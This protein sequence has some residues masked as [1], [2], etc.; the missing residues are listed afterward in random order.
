MFDFV[1]F[2]P[3]FQPFSSFFHSTFVHFFHPILF[4]LLTRMDMI[5]S[6]SLWNGANYN[7]IKVRNKLPVF[8]FVYV[9]LRLMGV[10]SWMWSGSLPVVSNMLRHLSLVW[11]D[12]LKCRFLNFFMAWNFVNGSETFG[13]WLWLTNDSQSPPDSSN[14]NTLGTLISHL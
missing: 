2:K 10:C 14:Y 7:R 3:A 9:C 11:L 5:S 12:K 13:A 4:S 6:S 1:F 8:S